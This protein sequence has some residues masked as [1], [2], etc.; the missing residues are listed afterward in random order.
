[1]S[2]Q[3]RYHRDGTVTVWDVY[4]QQWTRRPATELVAEAERPSPNAIMPT[5]N[6]RE[7]ERIERMAQ[8]MAR[9]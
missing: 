7:R 2:M 4:Q 1:M 6:A 5:L 9:A 3:T 8:R